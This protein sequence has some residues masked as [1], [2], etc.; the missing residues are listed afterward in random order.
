[1]EKRRHYKNPY[2]LGTAPAEVD[3]I[4]P[5]EAVPLGTPPDPLRQDETAP[6]IGDDWVP[7]YDDLKDEKRD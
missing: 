3:D 1:M 2:P 7:P 5:T 4:L 6:P